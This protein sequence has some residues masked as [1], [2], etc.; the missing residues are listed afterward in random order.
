MLNEQTVKVLEEKVQDQSFIG[1]LLGLED[2]AEVVGFLKSEGIELTIEEV[3]AIK[4][5]I[6]KKMESKESGEELSDSDLEEV[7][8]GCVMIVIG[9][10]T[11]II[12]LASLTESLTRGRW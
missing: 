3:D 12:E 2:N 8:G 5:G 6:I 7:S 4:N 11:G 1:K 9:I 10:I